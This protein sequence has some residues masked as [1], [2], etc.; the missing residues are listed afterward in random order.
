ML[1][2]VEFIVQSL[3]NDVQFLNLLSI[4]LSFT[5]ITHTFLREF[6]YLHIVIFRVEKLSFSVFELNPKGVDF[7]GESFDLNSLEDNDETL[8]F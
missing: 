2:F 3:A 8:G 5:L 4:L 1:H 7:D 6:T